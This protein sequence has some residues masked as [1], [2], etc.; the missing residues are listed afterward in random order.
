M[1]KLHI[2]FLCCVFAGLLSHATSYS[3]PRDL[4]KILQGTW[5]LVSVEYEGVK[6]L[7]EPNGPG[8]LVFDKNQMKYLLANGNQI[9]EALRFEIDSG[10]MPAAL[11]LYLNLGEKEKGPLRGII[12]V[13]G[14]KLEICLARLTGDVRPQVFK[15]ERKS[16][17]NLLL[18]VRE[19]PK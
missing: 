10:A 15:T 5:K 19:K 16:P 1:S 11:D 17:N 9:G 13:E 18:F 4:K 14:D 12:K 8:K 7:P 6:D 3:Q 2:R